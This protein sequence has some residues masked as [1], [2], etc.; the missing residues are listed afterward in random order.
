MYD[1]NLKTHKL[2]FSNPLY[3]SS[4]RIL[5]PYEIVYETYGNLNEQKDNAILITHALTGS[6]HCAGIYE[7]DKKSGWWDKL[8]GPKKAIDTNKYYVICSSSLGS[9]YGS[10]SPISPIY[11]SFG[12]NDY[13]RFKFPVIT[14][15]DITRAI[16]ILINRLKITKLHAV[17]GG[18]MGGMQA[19][20][21]AANYPKIAKRFIA[22]ACSHSSN[23]L[24]IMI[25]KIMSEII[26]LDKD[27]NNGKYDVSKKY[28]FK[29]LQIARMLGFSQY[30]SLNTMEQKFGRNYVST[31]GFYELF[32]R[33]EIER[34][35]EYNGAN[36]TKYFD[37]LCY[38]YLIK[39][40]S[41]FDLSLGFN[42]LNEALS[43]ILT[44]LHL[45]GFSGDGMFPITEMKGL[46]NALEHLGKKCT[47]EIIESEY[48]HDSFL[49]EINKIE[50][51]INYLVNL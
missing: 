30:I 36:F 18:S 50:D 35:L 1:L 38:L 29:G 28:T 17:I 16:A 9:P 11:G 34:Y 27:F 51:F 21:M 8:I 22:I 23:P 3:L 24:I 48:G 41:I 40:L 6:H 5:E 31:D 7:N 32:G 15:Q 26:L 44:P 13:Y 2:C 45:I 39:A 33:F 37:P 46:K 47:L 25:N 20:S 43:N 10:T 19:L 12:S 14:I 42:S 49:V 4:G